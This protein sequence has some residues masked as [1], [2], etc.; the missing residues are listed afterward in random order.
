LNGSGYPAAVAAWAKRDGCA[1]DPD[2]T[3]VSPHVIWRVY[4]CPVGVS[5]QF[6]IVVGGGHTWPGSAFTAK[7][8]SI[9][10]P[11][12]FEINASKII[13]AFFERYQV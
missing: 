3:K 4:R 1:A 2:N 12:T 8:A 7:I 9:T 6:Y 11:T 13:W 5:V 10:G